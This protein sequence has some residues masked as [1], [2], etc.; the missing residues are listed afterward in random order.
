MKAFCVILAGG[1]GAR[2]GSQIPKQ[3]LKLK[4]DPIIVWTIRRVLEC[5]DFTNVVVAVHPEWETQLRE[6]L[7]AGAIPADRIIITKGGA[8]RHDSILNALKAI[9]QHYDVGN[10]DVA[11][12]CDAVRPFVSVNTLKA[13]IVTAAEYGACVAAV[14]AV[15]TM[16]EVK[17]GVVVSVPPRKNLFH[18]QAPD[19]A[20]IL[21]LE[22][23]I[24]SL[25]E[26]ERKT[27]T[28]TAQILVLRGFPVKA[29]P[30]DPQNFK[31]TTPADFENAE[32]ILG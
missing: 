16:L 32:R 2:M 14:P 13:S 24:E 11:V 21:L 18:G 25:S 17:D 15:D 1:V 9:H 3:F 5:S 20:R 12:I 7:I 30:G 6:M 29:I 27:I 23:T 28:G 31:I 19:S 4:G 8:E 10:D 26:Y 22:R